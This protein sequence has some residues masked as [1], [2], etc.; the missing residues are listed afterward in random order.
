MK[1]YSH[2]RNDGSPS[3]RKFKGFN[4]YIQGNEKLSKK[5]RKRLLL[6]SENHLG[7]V[8]HSINL[9]TEQ[10][11]NLGLTDELDSK[12]TDIEL[13]DQWNHM[14][15]NYGYLMSEFRKNWEK[16]K[17]GKTPPLKEPSIIQTLISKIESLENQVESIQKRLKEIETTT[18]S[19]GSIGF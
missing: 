6:E 11:I 1:P 15:D 14:Y 16:E 2:P 5:N 4:F 8:Y 12:N 17:I 18:P 7:E 3:K 13:L 10:K 19:L 9:S